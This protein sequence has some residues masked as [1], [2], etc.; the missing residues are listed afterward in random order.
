MRAE[1]IV[2]LLYLSWFSRYGLCETVIAD[3]GSN[4]HAPA[5]ANSLHSMGI[6]LRVAPTEAPWSIG[7]TERHHGPIRSVFLRARAESPSVH[8]DLLL[9]LAYKARNDAP[10]ASGASPTTA[11]FGERPRLLVGDNSHWDMSCA[12]RA[13]AAQAASAALQSYTVWARLQGA[14][15]HP[16]TTVPYVTVG[17]HVL[18]YREKDGWLHGRVTSI[19]GKDV[20]VLRDGKLFSAHESRV[21][22]YVDSLLHAPLY[23]KSRTDLSDRN[24]TSTTDHHTH[25][26]S[27][28]PANQPP[29]PPHASGRPAPTPPTVPISAEAR[30]FHSSAAAAP[31]PSSHH[32]S[33][34]H[35]AKVTEVSSFR[36]LGA[37]TAVPA[38]AVPPGAQVFP[39]TWRCTEN[40]DRGN[41]KPPLRARFCMQGHL[42]HDKATNVSTAPVVS[43]KAIR[44][45]TTAAAILEWDLR[46]EDFKRAYLQADRLPEPVYTRIPPEAGEPDSHVWAFNRPIHGKDDAGRPFFFTQR[47][48]ILTTTD[49]TPSHIHDAVYYSP[50]LGAPCTY[51]DDTYGAGLPPFMA[52]VD[53]LMSSFR[54][55]KSDVNDV[56]VAGVHISRTALGISTDGDKYPQ[57]LARIPTPAGVPDDA[58]LLYPT[59]YKSVAAS[60]LWIARITRP[61]RACDASLPCN[62]P[63]PTHGDAINL[64]KLTA[65]TRDN[66]LPLTY[67]RLDDSTLR[68]A[69]YA[70]YSGSPQTPAHRHHQGHPIVATDASHLF[71]L[72]HWESGRPRRTV[73]STGGGELLALADALQDAVDIRALLAELLDRHIPISVHT[74]AATACV[75]GFKEPSELLRKPDAVLVRQALLHGTLAEVCRL[76]SADNPADALSEPSF[77]RVKPN[78][79]LSTALA[80]GY[81]H[82]PIR[83]TTTSASARNGLLTGLTFK[84]TP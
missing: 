8:A 59:V 2:G 52:K 19:D 80:S 42:A 73:H 63:T 30:I 34:W 17:Q 51:S 9:A 65:F 22:P 12:A 39:Y 78:P 69:A 82:T 1:L 62:K 38:S 50:R 24:P 61:D 26:P 25:F 58:P 41:G 18:F 15:S 6:H 36:S 44:A 40:P 53:A 55:H 71:A 49:R 11:V 31:P 3:R 68:I 79:T 56:R 37:V 81:L 32:H 60:H 46:T 21:K 13:H 28:L 64:N 45:V 84:A 27:P 77:L 5:V 76:G 14:L 33:R 29:P 10:P 72:L 75:V 23:E 66:P 43:L 47:K 70:D 48:A 7:K 20:Y 67:P 35:D 4:L 74:D 57:R 83:A 16:G 54:T